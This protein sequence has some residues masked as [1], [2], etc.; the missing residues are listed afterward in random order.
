[1][2]KKIRN[3]LKNSIFISGMHRSGTSWVS[4]IL[5]T[6]GRYVLKD[7]EMFLPNYPSQTKPIKIW[8]EYI[9]EPKGK[10]EDI[11]N[12]LKEKNLNFTEKTV[13]DF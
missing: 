10:R 5:S 3:K 12:F 1:M 4:E 11:P 6:A 2:D 7:E 13:K 8:Y 9:Q